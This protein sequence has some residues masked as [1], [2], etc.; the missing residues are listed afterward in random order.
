MSRCCHCQHANHNK[1]NTEAIISSNDRKHLR[2]WPVASIAT[3]YE[4]T[5]NWCPNITHFGSI[6]IVVVFFL[7]CLQ[8][9]N[10]EIFH[11]HNHYLKLFFCFCC[12]Q[13]IWKKFLII[14]CIAAVF[15]ARKYGS[16]NHENSSKIQ[17]VHRCK[18]NGKKKN[19]N[20]Y[21]KTE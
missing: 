17:Y 4:N 18:M 8:N 5:C 10:Y 14:L 11:R 12:F 20:K 7:F 1:S 19:G 16:K 6:K 9:K 21:L 13:R 3:D 2:L 15:Q